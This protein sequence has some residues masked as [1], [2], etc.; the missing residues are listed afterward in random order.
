VAAFA[1]LKNVPGGPDFFLTRHVFEKAL[2]HINASVEPV[3]RCVLS[4]GREAGQDMLAGSIF[5]GYIEFCTK[6]AARP[7]KAIELIEE[8]PD[9]LADMLTA[10]IAAGSQLDIHHYLREVLR[11]IRH[12][13]MEVRRRA[14][15]SMARLRW[16]KGEK[17][18]DAAIVA[19]EDVASRETDDRILA[20]TIGSAFA[21]FEQDDTYRERLVSVVGIALAMGAD[22]ALHAASELLWL[23]T[24]KLPNEL[25]QLLLANLKQVK[26]ENVGT[27]NNIDYGVA[28]LLKR[29]DPEPGLEFLKELLVVHR[30]ELGIKALDSTVAEI[31]QNPR[32]IGKLLTR[33][34]LRGERALCEA[35]REIINTY[36]GDSDDLRVEIDES[37]LET[38][39]RTHMI[40]VAHKTIGY[41]FIKPV[42]AASILLSLMRHAK[43]DET[44]CWLPTTT[45][46]STQN[47]RTATTAKMQRARA[48]SIRQSRYGQLF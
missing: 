19:L 42:T 9:A 11:L 6:D 25:L 34:F 29:D 43:E 10:T 26:I 30:G 22:S 18:P 14:V 47:Q 41:F 3:M 17:V 28:N 31:L 39:N 45:S 48:S 21:L 37:E 35:V 33:W 12:P 4:L 27:L 32:L 13:D 15:F 40:L 24:Q 2:P 23:H 36:H 1:S 8:A 20:G 44:L 16:P 46:L 5:N 7:I 38:S